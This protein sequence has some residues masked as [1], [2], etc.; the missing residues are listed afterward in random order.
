M[1]KCHL[2]FL[3]AK[4]PTSKSTDQNDKKGTV[5]QK[6]PK[7][8]KIIPKKILKTQFEIKIKLNC[9]DINM[10]LILKELFINI[11]GKWFNNQTRN[12]LKSIEIEEIFS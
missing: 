4:N 6:I 3:Y 8:M 2:R 9:V 10:T 12:H 11:I 1:D 5:N 7:S